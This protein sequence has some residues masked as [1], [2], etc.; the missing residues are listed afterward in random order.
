MGNY[1]FRRKK[2]KITTKGDDNVQTGSIPFKLYIP[3][4][5][6]GE[7]CFFGYITHAQN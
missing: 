2:K 1:K 3:K 5:M 7:D 4:L 6:V